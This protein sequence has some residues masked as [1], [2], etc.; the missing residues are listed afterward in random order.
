M[1]GAFQQPERVPE[2]IHEQI[3][4][5]QRASR[6]RFHDACPP[7]DSHSKYTVCQC[8]HTVYQPRHHS[9]RAR[10]SHIDMKIDQHSSAYPYPAHT[11]AEAQKYD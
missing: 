2:S 4:P 8:R 1:S 3:L 11:V 7:L 9:R 10:S 5:F 6:E